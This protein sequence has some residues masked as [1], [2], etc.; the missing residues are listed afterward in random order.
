MLG[1]DWMEQETTTVFLPVSCLSGVA[2]ANGIELVPSHRKK[3]KKKQIKER[4]RE[5]ERER[6]KM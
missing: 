6:E 3:K 4:E 2:K 5:R 1:A